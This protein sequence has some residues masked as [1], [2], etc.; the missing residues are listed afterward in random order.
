MTGANKGIG[1]ATC[2]LLLE[3]HPDV[4]VLLG[5]RDMGR[6]E[7]AVS[8]LK[9]AVPG[10]EDRLEL[11]QIDTSNDESVSKAA[12]SVGAP[13]YGIIN[14]AGI[15]FEHSLKDIVNVNY[16]G[17]RRVTTAFSKYLQ[18]P[19]GRIVHIA[20]AGGP[21]FIE[22]CTNPELRDHLSKPLTIGSIE[23]LDKIAEANMNNE[24][25]TNGYQFSKA[26]VNAY[27]VL[28][29][30]DEPD[31]IINACT[32]GWIATDMTVGM[33]AK[34]PPSQG[35]VPPVYLCMSEDFDK[36]PTGRYYGSDCIR[37][38]LN[39]YRG[40]GDPPYEGE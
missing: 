11:V 29:A 9:S 33:G 22:G 13:L 23:S 39:I 38:P 12:E 35:A 4:H 19:G 26:L 32:P 28:H 20:S 3:K 16:F 1:K 34:N 8:D 25:I 2:Q 14:N 36:L 30:A 5:S 15:G 31:L 6:G 21:R 27:N 17:S 7:Q 40:P 37:S 18:K 10:C 24:D